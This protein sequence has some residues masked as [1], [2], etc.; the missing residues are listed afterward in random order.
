VQL[1]FQDRVT[2]IMSHVKQNID[3]LRSALE[4]NC[5]S[6]TQDRQLQ[7]L[8]AAGL[9]ASLEKTYAMA[10]EYALDRQTGPAGTKQAPALPAP[11][12]EVTFF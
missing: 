12:D 1:Q 11:A 8:D 3:L 7:P 6:Y 9:L 5:D 2:Q 4:Q 10:E